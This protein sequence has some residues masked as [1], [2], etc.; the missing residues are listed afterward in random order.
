VRGPQNAVTQT[1]ITLHLVYIT[2]Q[3]PLLCWGA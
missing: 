3:Q 2:M 1:D